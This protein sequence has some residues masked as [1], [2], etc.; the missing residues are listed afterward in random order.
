MTAEQSSES[1]SARTE[2][3][4]ESVLD[5]VGHTPLIRLARLGA[6]LPAAVYLNLDPPIWFQGCDLWPMGPPR[7]LPVVFRAGAF[8][9]WP[10]GARSSG[11]LELWRAVAWLSIRW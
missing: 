7:S 5:A 6:G 1:L 2:P 4:Y 9:G 3:V 8:A 11:F 10:S